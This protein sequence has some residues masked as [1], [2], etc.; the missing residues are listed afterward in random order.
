MHPAAEP[1]P[2]GL[3]KEERDDVLGLFVDGLEIDGASAID[4]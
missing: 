2:H 3:E 1:W 4:G